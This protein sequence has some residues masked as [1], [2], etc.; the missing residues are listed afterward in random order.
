MVLQVNCPALSRALQD[1]R[2]TSF[3][4]VIKYSIAF[5]M[6]DT[7]PQRVMM[8]SLPTTSTHPGAS[9]VTIAHPAS[10]ASNRTTGKF[11]C[12]EGNTKI[13]EVL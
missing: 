8:A 2:T 5:L 13:L 11:S 7:W 3:S 12:T 10:I 6:S 1:K 9:V 4:F